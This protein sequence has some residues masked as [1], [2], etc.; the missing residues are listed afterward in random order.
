MS[1]AIKPVWSGM[2]VSAT[3]AFK[4]ALQAQLISQIWTDDTLK[5]EILITPKTVL[6]REIAITFPPN[7]TIKVLEEDTGCFYFIVPHKPVSETEVLA[8]LEQMSGWWMAAHVGWWWASRLRFPQAEA[9]REALSAMI[10]GH[11]WMDDS[12]RQRMLTD[13]KAALTE[14]TGIIFPPGLE[15]KTLEETAQIKY[16]VLP[17]SSQADE[18]GAHVEQLSEWW[19]T[20]HTFWSWLVWLRLHTPISA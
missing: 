12:F 8:R 3:G 17:R 10:I 20:T 5:Q 9:F 19:M 16:L 18:L 14:E 11:V 1:T 13:P 4:E 6:E 15:I 2:D 7:V